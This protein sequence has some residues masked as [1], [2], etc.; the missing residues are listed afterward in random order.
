L[1]GIAY[2]PDSADVRRRSSFER[3]AHLLS[4][5]EP[6]HIGEFNR[7]EKSGSPTPARNVKILQFGVKL[8]QSWVKVHRLGSLGG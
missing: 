5:G 7:R 3:C 2:S 8:S 6:L 4:G 1:A